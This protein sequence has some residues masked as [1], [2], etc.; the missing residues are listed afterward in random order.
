[1]A[2]FRGVV[3]GVAVCR[4]VFMFWFPFMVVDWLSDAVRSLAAIVFFCL[5]N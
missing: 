2:I 5:G 4:L 1:M 3:P